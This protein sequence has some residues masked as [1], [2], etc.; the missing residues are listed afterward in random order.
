MGASVAERTAG[1]APDDLQLLKS[2]ASS[3][4]PGSS[5]YDMLVQVVFLPVFFDWPCGSLFACIVRTTPEATATVTNQSALVQELK[6]IKVQQKALPRQWAELQRN[7]TAA[8]A[9]ASAAAA[10]LAAFSARLA[11]AE[12]ALAACT[13]RLSAGLPDT[14]LH[15]QSELQEVMLRLVCSRL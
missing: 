14:T 13:P 7:A 2:P 5:V 8:Q 4:R 6:A 12:A 9:A 10:E 15:V 3:A 11:A 1:A